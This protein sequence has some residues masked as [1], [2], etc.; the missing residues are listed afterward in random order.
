MDS[1]TQVEGPLLQKPNPV[2]MDPIRKQPVQTFV[3]LGKDKTKVSIIEDEGHSYGAILAEFDKKKVARNRGPY[4]D[5]YQ[6]H[7]SF[8]QYHQVPQHQ[9]A[10]IAA[11]LMQCALDLKPFTVRSWVV[12]VVYYLKSLPGTLCLMTIADP[13]TKRCICLK[14]KDKGR[15]RRVTHFDHQHTSGQ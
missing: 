7:S 5:R 9:L 10:S 11:Q 6:S 1:P 12:R 8:P 13:M 3:S 4:A 15:E 14:F 2:Y